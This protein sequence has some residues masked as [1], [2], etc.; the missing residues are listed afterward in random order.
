MDFLPVDFQ[1]MYEV[2]GMIAIREGL[3]RIFLCS[4]YVAAQTE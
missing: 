1:K 3:R 4:S 2:S